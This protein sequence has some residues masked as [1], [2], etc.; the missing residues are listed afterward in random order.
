MNK[1]HAWSIPG[2]AETIGVTISTLYKEIGSGKLRTF[3]IGR[4]RLVSDEALK[5]YIADR[6]AE[7]E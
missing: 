3:K 4:R 5:Q 6:E 7:P 1:K 2:S